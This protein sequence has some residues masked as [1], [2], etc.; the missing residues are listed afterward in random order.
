M[1]DDVNKKNFFTD[2][3]RTSIM[4]STNPQ[5]AARLTPTFGLASY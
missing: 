1:R 5:Q 3:D 4:R 2:L